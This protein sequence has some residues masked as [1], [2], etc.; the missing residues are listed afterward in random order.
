MWYVNVMDRAIDYADQTASAIFKCDYSLL[1]K[2]DYLKFTTTTKT[3]ELMVLYIASGES[4]CMFCHNHI[5][6]LHDNCINS[7]QRR[8]IVF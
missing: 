4:F 8:R 3:S 1:V 6:Y 2:G 7:W 5:S